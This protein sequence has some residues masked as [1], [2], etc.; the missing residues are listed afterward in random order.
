MKEIIKLDHM[1]LVISKAYF[2]GVNDA[3]GYYNET[4]KLRELKPLCEKVR[5]QVEKYL[6]TNTP[7]T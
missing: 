3:I 5:E 4:A 2:L 6:S 1:D 7:K